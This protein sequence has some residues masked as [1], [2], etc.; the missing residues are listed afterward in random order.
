M[1]SPFD[2]T[3]PTQLCS[4]F[5]AVLTLLESDLQDFV[6]R[7]PDKDISDR[8]SRLKTLRVI[9]RGYDH[10]WVENLRIRIERDRMENMLMAS[11]DE[12]KALKSTIKN[13]ENDGT[14]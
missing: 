12:I 4:A 1:T 10:L 5:N 2:Y 7:N 9:E 13:L 11:M 3:D 6:I 14:E 8:I